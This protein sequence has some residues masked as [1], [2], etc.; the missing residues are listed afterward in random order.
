MVAD[1]CNLK[2][3]AGPVEATVLGNMLVQLMAIDEIKNIDDGLKI[4]NKIGDVHEYS[5]RQEER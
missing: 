1:T 2:V 3:K 5:P 4:I